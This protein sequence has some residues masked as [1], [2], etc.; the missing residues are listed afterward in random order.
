MNDCHLNE[1][2]GSG[3]K[4]VAGKEDKIDEVSMQIVNNIYMHSCGE[5]FIS[6]PLVSFLWFS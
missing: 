6:M 1:P 2:D 4:V 3:T 5:L